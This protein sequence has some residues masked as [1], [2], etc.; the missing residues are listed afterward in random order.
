MSE[1]FRDSTTSRSRSPSVFASASSF[2]MTPAYSTCART[3]VAAR[4][5]W[6]ASSATNA[7]P[8]VVR[9]ILVGAQA[10][11]VPLRAAAAAKSNA[12]GRM[13][14]RNRRAIEK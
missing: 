7:R 5:N 12:P 9:S 13:T 3:G 8:M 10:P 4:V 6:V 14:G 2:A 1:A 11:R